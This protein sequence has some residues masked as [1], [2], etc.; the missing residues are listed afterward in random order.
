MHWDGIVSM[1]EGQGTIFWSATAAASLGLALLIAAGAARARQIV[2]S[3]RANRPRVERTPQDFSASQRRTPRDSPA[4][5]AS[6]A[7]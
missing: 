7:I 1:M 6:G 5:G 3:Y 4:G 2:L